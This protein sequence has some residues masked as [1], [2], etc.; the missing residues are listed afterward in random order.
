VQVNRVGGTVLEG[1]RNALGVLAPAVG[2]ESMLAT[3]TA[4]GLFGA[5]RTLSSGGRVPQAD[6]SPTG[7]FWVVWQQVSYSYAIHAIFGP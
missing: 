7:R 2:M 3:F 1:D 6:S 4:A 5:A